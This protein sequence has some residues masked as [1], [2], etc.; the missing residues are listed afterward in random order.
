MRAAARGFTLVEV[1]LASMLSLLVITGAFASLSVMLRAYRDSAERSGGAELA[2]MVF[3][4][5]RKDLMSVYIS[6]HR[7][8]TQFIGVEN[9]A[10]NG[11]DAHILT[12]IS[13]VNDPIPYQTHASDLAEIQYYVDWNDDTPERW[14]VRRFD[15]LPDEDPY[16]GGEIALLGP[17]VAL[18]RFNYFDGELWWPYW[19][20]EGEIPML[21]NITIGIFQPEREWDTPSP[22]NIEI[23]TTTM[24]PA[25]YRQ[26]EGAGLDGMMMGAGSDTIGAGGGL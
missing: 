8:A 18:L 24:R 26:T 11:M 9:Y 6:P 1:L 19:E 21:I 13:F 20:F 15:H 17:R 2:N 3:N 5:M 12:F 25:M 23:F 7:D 22:E 16:S 4:R 14:L 10:P